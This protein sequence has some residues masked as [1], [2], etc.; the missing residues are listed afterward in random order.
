MFPALVVILY[1]STV[2]KLI[3]MTT[4]PFRLSAVSLHV[5]DLASFFVEKPSA[6]H[7]SG[8]VQVLQ[9][10]VRDPIR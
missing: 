8:S 9:A 4:L 6:T 1:C 5:V 2:I 10:R 3:W 7:V